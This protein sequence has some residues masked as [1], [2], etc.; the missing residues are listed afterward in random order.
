MDKQLLR[1][2]HDNEFAPPEDRTPMDLLPDLMAG[3]G[4]LD[5]ELRDSLC[6][7]IL[8]TWIDHGLYTPDQV[9]EIA[10]RLMDNLRE[11]I[12]E[13]EG[14][15]VFLRTFSVLILG[16]IVTYDARVRF[17]EAGEVHAI[18][19][20]GLT[21]LMDEQD[22]RGYVPGKGWA[23]SV[24]HTADLLGAVAGHPALGAP[25]LERILAAI[26]QKVIAPTAY[27]YLE[28]E[29]GRLGRAVLATLR[30]EL[31]PMEQV[32]ACLHTLAGVEPRYKAFVPGRDSAT[33]HNA[34]CFLRC[35]HLLLAH[36]EL[37][38]QA[39]EQLPGVVY[40]VMKSFTPWGL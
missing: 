22:L 33:Y 31:L 34:R 38:A 3:L 29:D 11:G 21:Y 23:H 39:R 13:A 20:C 32:A 19:A 24:A 10:R 8:W 26:V 36:P 35:L 37:P 14:D 15:R 9:R 5:P 6:L 28:N 40:T 16:A 4:A 18:Q 30:R 17:L 2:I 7:E 1:R 12:G 25:D 27:P